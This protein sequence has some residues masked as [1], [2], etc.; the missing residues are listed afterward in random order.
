MYGQNVTILRFSMP[1][2]ANLLLRE[3]FGFLK[4]FFS[5]NDCFKFHEMCQT[6]IVETLQKKK[7]CHGIYQ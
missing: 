3:C 2:S 1:K 5:V 7:S 6:Y 4:E